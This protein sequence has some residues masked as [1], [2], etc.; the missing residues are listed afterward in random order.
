[1][2]ARQFTTPAALE[3]GHPIMEIFNGFMLV[4]EQVLPE[5]NSAARFY[6]H[7][8]TGAEL[9]SLVNDDDNKTF[10]VTFRTLPRDSTGVAHILEHAVLCGSRKYPV[11]EP[12]VELMKGSL[13]TFLNAMTF[14]DKT[15][16]PVASQNLKDFYNLIDVYLDA[17]FYPRISPNAFQQEGWHYELDT[18]DAPL[19]YKGVVFNEMKGSYSSP[20]DRLN[21]FSQRSLFPDTVYGVDSGGDPRHIPDLTYAEFKAFH[22]RYYHPSNA[23]LFFYGDDDPDKRLRLLDSWLGAFDTIAVDS[24]VAPQKRFSAPRRL[25]RTFVTSAGK[26]DLKAM[27]TVNW[28]IDQI[29][30]T[31]TDLG[32]GILE[33]ILIGT[34][35]SPLRK[36]LVDS[37]LGE[38]IAGRGLDEELLQP[39]FSV[40]LKGI[41]RSGTEK[42]ESLIIETLRA[43]A[44]EGVDQMTV[45]ASLST[46]EFHLRENNFGSFPRGVAAML[47]SLKT[48]LY[49]RDPLA[50]LAFEA[51]L[52]TLKNRITGGECYFEN[53]IAR[54]LL[55]NPHRTTLTL[56]PDPEQ[57]ERDAAAER[58]RLDAARA[59][60]SRS[61]LE[62]LVEATCTLKRLQETPDPPEA[63][64]T[65]PTLTLEDLPRRNKVIPI[66][67]SRE[68]DTQVLYHAL[69]TNGVLYLDL[70]LDLHVLPADL[71]PYVPLFA[72]AV[73]ETGADQQDFVSL[74]QRI[75]RSTG[76]IRP[77][78]WISAVLDS[79]LAAARLFLRAKAIP[80]KAPE[81]LAILSDVLHGARLGDQERLHQL[82]LEEKVTKESSLVPAGA[83]FVGMRL[84]AK[85]HEA[86]WA[87]ENLS[88]I[89]YLRFL[90][91][92]ADG[93]EARWPTVRAA[94]ERIRSL[95]VNRRALLCNVTT[96]A[97]SWR[98]FEPELASF[99]NT[100]PSD[101]IA[102]SSWRIGEGPRSE[103]LAIPASVNYVGK[104]G[105]LY[106]L[107]FKPSG[108]AHVVVKYLRTTWLWDKVRVQGGA[109]GG[110]CTFDH[111]SGNF[112]FLSYRDPNLLETLNIYD[113]TPAFLKRA[114][115]DQSELTR[116]IIGTIGDIDAY[117]LP[118][119]KGYTSLQRYLAGETD[120][121]RQRRRD[122]ILS[123]SAA[124]FRDFA[125]VLADLTGEA[126]LVVFGSEQ[127]IQAVNTRRPGFLHVSKVI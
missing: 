53:L 10:G 79:R 125:K 97:A 49:D 92:L 65:I 118:D 63:L 58:Q 56:R 69:S 17:V 29:P 60:M 43:L 47:R 109:Y 52:R 32:I 27:A 105:N 33:H 45:E 100:L 74:S 113:Q 123:A 41:D 59:T 71:L 24:M 72:R 85:L 66:E 30:D 84:R 104:G 54:Y 111:R 119:A 12:F 1:L 62:A 101:P 91:Q 108:A 116:G 55:D 67:V 51:A 103:A 86:D 37:G 115:P 40:G 78:V 77:Q 61:D 8:K 48:W 124:D 93:F 96:D 23:R 14:P 21:E 112:T 19:V 126:H 107:G 122:E 94:M 11:K 44:D 70:G 42:V 110:F 5:L 98:R 4:R 7:A 22:R 68:A 114:E 6:R 16:Y 120:E 2:F 35:A 76:G 3:E 9:L 89:S 39:M 28:M 87:E 64:A 127:A 20:D 25:S 81:L 102:Q 90:H 88:G 15:C 50:P 31:E 83:H 75:G 80:E 106:R 46:V 82:V 95:L 34:P 38:D 26:A 18:V 117:Q 13:N 36:A 99:L 73:L 57:A 121:V